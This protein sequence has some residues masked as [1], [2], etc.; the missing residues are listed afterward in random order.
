MV[1]LHGAGGEESYCVDL[2]EESPEIP[3]A[4]EMLRIVAQD[5]VSQARFFVLA[6]RVARGECMDNVWVVQSVLVIVSRDTSGEEGQLDTELR[7]Y[8]KANF[9]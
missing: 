6:I 9:P 7:R 4:R 3:S 8:I 2:L 5:P 1:H